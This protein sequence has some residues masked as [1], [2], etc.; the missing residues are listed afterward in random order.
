LHKV[1][2]RKFGESYP[3]LPTRALIGI[4]LGGLRAL[5]SIGNVV[6]LILVNLRLR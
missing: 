1:F 2:Y 5:E 3:W 4:Q 6:E